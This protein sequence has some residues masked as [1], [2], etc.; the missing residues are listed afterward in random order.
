MQNAALSSA[1]W[2]DGG[3]IGPRCLAFLRRVRAGGGAY[4]LVRNADREAL[5]RALAA[6]FVAWVCRSRH[7]VRLTA[8][9]A[10]Y[11]DR[12]ARVE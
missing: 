8:R 4:K 1:S 12:L 3:P 2:T 9:G 6:G 11:L 5:D 7:D 10:E